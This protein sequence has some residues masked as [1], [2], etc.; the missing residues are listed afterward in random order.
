[1]LSPLFFAMAFALLTTGSVLA[2]ARRA[3]AIGVSRLAATVSAQLG[4]R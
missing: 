1:M 4:L 3:D 2:D